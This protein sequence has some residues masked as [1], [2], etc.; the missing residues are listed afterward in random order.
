MTI[1]S[2]QSKY[3]FVFELNEERSEYV[4]NG[5]R[6]YNRARKSPLWS[7]FSQASAPL[8]I[9]ALGDNGFVVGGLIGETNEIPEWLNVSVVWVAEEQ[10]G[11]GIGRHL[12]SLAEEEAKR[13]SCRYARLA[14]GD[15]QAPDF[16]KKIGYKIYGK[17]E[18]CPQGETIY[19]FYKELT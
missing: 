3:S 5:L 12:M 19:Y 13:R 17:L 11:E 8:E 6:E 7:N 15:Y 10:R 1:N 4:T 2:E 16:Y 18:N 9:Y 14:T